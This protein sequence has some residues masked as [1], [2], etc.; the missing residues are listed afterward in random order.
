MIPFSAIIRVFLTTIADLHG[1]SL[2]ILC[3]TERSATA[4]ATATYGHCYC[5][6]S[7]YYYHPPAT[8]LSAGVER[9]LRH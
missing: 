4:T 2:L 6:C 3:A 5:Y 1:L 9:L 7:L 8:T